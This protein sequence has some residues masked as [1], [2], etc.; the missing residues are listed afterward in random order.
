MK[1][2]TLDELENAIEIILLRHFNH[3]LD[4]IMADQTA[5]A[6]ALVTLDTDVKALIAS[7]PVATPPVD[8]QP[9][10]DAINAID[11]EVKAATP[12]PSPAPSA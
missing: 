3:K 9:Q 2:I 4:Q 8:L 1:N 10:V 11:A 6:A 7:I 5:V 12:A